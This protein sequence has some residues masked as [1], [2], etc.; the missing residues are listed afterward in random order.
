LAFDSKDFLRRRVV[1]DI[2]P[3][4]KEPFLVE[5]T[6][7]YTPLGVGVEF[8][9]TSAFKDVCVKRVKELSQQFQLTQKRII[10]DSYSLRE[11]LTHYKAIPFCDQLVQ[12]LTRYIELVHFTYVILPPDQFP[13]VPVGGYRSPVY[14]IRS[15]EF[16]RN[17]GPMFSYISAWAYLGKRS[18][19]GELLLDAFNSRQTNAWNELL[20][21]NTPKIFPHGDE[22]NPY[23]ML[24]DIFAYLTDAKLYTQKKGLRPESLKE[25]WK[26]YG[27]QVDSHF[28]DI[29]TQPMYKWNCEDQIDISPYLARP[30]VF[31]MVDDIEKLQS[32]PQK[33]ITETVKTPNK[34]EIEVTSTII[35]EE[36]R[37]KDL[38]KHMEPWYS[39]TAYA[40][41]KGG[42][43]QL[44][45][46]RMD[47]G[48]VRDGDILVYI[49]NQSKSLAESFSHFLDVK[50]LSAKE[51]RNFIKTKIV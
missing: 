5:E 15:P 41:L 20:T 6:T 34:E 36:K 38:V 9:N 33:V 32:D 16:L 44:F 24:S 50:V 51:V 21:K 31:L 1:Q 28:L 43:G 49:G 18:I 35:P 3:E 13:T 29:N 40:Y 30:M 39:V 2:D 4:T 48:K 22:C 11:E 47:H 19:S 17:L 25:I 10:Y 37:F 7:F 14:N 8:N 46:Y 45:N 23:I 26:N 27:F 12:K 42:A